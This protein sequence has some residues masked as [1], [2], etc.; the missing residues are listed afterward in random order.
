M[1]Q[2]YACEHYEDL[3]GNMFGNKKCSKMQLDPNGFAGAMY[4][5]KYAHASCYTATSYHVDYNNPDG[6]SE[7][8][9]YENECFI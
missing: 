2:C 7:N 4:C 8:T 1:S 3:D 5:P 6:S 9:L